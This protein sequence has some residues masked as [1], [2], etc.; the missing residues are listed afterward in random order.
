MQKKKTNLG[1]RVHMY[2]SL[3]EMEKQFV[4]DV[5][6]IGTEF[7]AI[8]NANFDMRNPWAQS[9]LASVAANILAYVEV[10][11]EMDDVNME[12]SIKEFYRMS[13]E[14]YRQQAFKGK[15]VKK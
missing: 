15:K 6:V 12:K 14:D 7:E 11:A 10:Y 13:L 3:Q 4:E 2:E 5:A 1:K 9:V 8:I